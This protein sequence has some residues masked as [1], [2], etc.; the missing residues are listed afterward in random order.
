M[1]TKGKVVWEEDNSPVVGYKIEL[2]DKDIIN[3]DSIGITYTDSAGMYEINH[4]QQTD[5]FWGRGDFYIIVKNHDGEE[6]FKSSV[7]NDYSED[8][9]TINATLRNRIV[10]LFGINTVYGSVALAYSNGNKTPLEGAKVVIKDDDLIFDDLLGETKTDSEGNYIVSFKQEDYKK[11]GEIFEGSADIFAS[12]Y[13][14]E[15]RNSG[16]NELFKKVWQ[17]R[18]FR[19]AILPYQLNIKIPVMQIKGEVESYFR[20]DYK[21]KKE[22][23]HPTS[24]LK[25]KV[26][27]VDNILFTELLEESSVVN[28]KFNISITGS[29]DF[30]NEPSGNDFYIKLVD[31]NDGA[32]VWMSE[33]FYN[34]DRAS[35][36]DANN[37]QPIKAILK[38]PPKTTQQIQSYSKLRVY[39]CHTERRS[40]DIWLRK[41]DESGQPV[42]EYIN[43]GTIVSQYDEYG[44]CPIGDPF[45]ITLE[46]GLFE[47]IAV[48]CSN[49]ESFPCR[50]F[51][52]KVQGNPNSEK[53]FTITIS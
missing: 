45:E 29:S 39:N 9:L 22:T 13:I 49:L 44:S 32:T 5:V 41:Y 12:V 28:N 3:D 48:D 25:V 42:G 38:C 20:C 47:V 46:N 31:K 50:R 36:L 27:D 11:W 1:I 18:V 26:Y 14:D 6:I 2:W 17:T 43:K 40:V 23:E 15:N 52:I 34:Q 30:F 7:Y 33:I 51:Q 24:D 8:T 35:V 4:L 10:S 19:E 21:L 53:E 16:R 37:G